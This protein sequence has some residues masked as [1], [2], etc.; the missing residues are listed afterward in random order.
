LLGKATDADA[1]RLEARLQKDEQ[2]VRTLQ[3]LEDDLFDEYAR[4]TLSADDARRF[5]ER[6]GHET[7]RLAFA[8]A[9]ATRTRRVG[10]G[11]WFG[12][13]WW[14]PMALAAALVLAVGGYQLTRTSGPESSPEMGRPAKTPSAPP[15]VLALVTLGSSRA[16]RGAP[17]ITL[18]KD[19]GA[20]QLRVRLN[21]A[22][23][24]DRYAMELRSASNAVVWRASDR[25]P[26]SEAG[27]M[28]IEGT[29]PAMSVGDGSYELAVSGLTAPSAPE[30]LGFVQVRIARTP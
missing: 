13:F 14:M 10:S 19:A 25:R 27:D 3:S 21:P 30:P 26:A 23:R 18:P 8:R 9:L 28:L 20:I 12:G 22:D 4:N 29:V 11:H 16:E 7:D 2:L 24:Y 17:V 1:A 15:T 5:L 6:Y